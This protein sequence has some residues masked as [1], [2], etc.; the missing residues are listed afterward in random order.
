MSYARHLAFEM[1]SSKPDRRFNEILE[2][3]RC[4]RNFFG[5]TEN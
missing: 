2:K 4:A 5:E 3:C 1:R